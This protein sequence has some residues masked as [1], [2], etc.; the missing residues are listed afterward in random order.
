M[1]P[2]DHGALLDDAGDDPKRVPV[3]LRERLPAAW[4]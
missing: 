3:V 2:A 4:T 1:V